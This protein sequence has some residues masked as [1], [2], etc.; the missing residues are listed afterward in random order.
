MSFD[1]IGS[2][3]PDSDLKSR[4][5]AFKAKADAIAALP[6][7]TLP[8][9]NPP[10]PLNCETCRDSGWVTV[11]E[12]IGKCPDCRQGYADGVPYEFQQA[13]LENYRDDA[14]NRAALAKAR[15]FITGTRDLYL[16]GGV[17]AGKTR[18]ACSILNEVFRR[19][20]RALFVRVPM[21]L[22]QLQP[23]KDNTE[24]ESRLFSVPLL[25][26]DDIGAERDQATD[27]TRRTL[28]MI[29]EQRGDRGLR[30][31]W[32]SNKTIQQLSDMQDDDRLAS[33]IA[34][35]ADV[36]LL[37]TPDQRLRRVK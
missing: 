21:V 17:G 14:G 6:P 12:A 27:Y 11:G 1:R 8:R 32:T 7:G 4:L 30:T 20:R 16:T 19:T 15:A 25:V 13:A 33:R 37:T 22:H 9:R 5:A 31:I 2:V 3:E 24:L 10:T 18:L 34:G 29:Y 36:V 28:L 35:R 26:M 23:G